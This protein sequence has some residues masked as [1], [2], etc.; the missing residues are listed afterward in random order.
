MSE[1]TR[2][3][4][5]GSD[6]VRALLRH[7][8]KSR[9]MTAEDKAR[10]RARVGRVAAGIAVGVGSLAWL[11]GVAIGAGLGLL[12]V[13]AAT[14]APALLSP[15]APSAVVTAR[16]PVSG[17]RA[18]PTESAASTAPM[19]APLAPPP[20]AA[21]V[22]TAPRPAARPVEAP[23]SSSR[24]GGTEPPSETDSLAQEAALLERARAALGTSPAEALSL[25]ETHASRFPAG[26]LGMERELVALD[27]LRHL[28]RTAEV[29]TRGEALLSRGQGGLY[30]ERIHK[31]LDGAH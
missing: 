6:P 30:A 23:P 12:T 9:G 14:I 7:A 24:G 5:E 19:D 16:A 31:L 17:P 11:Q 8:P 13:G 21:P 4:D 29:R 26:K 20:S 1:P 10:T 2:L 28:G 22:E 27:A 3:R 18:H 15:A 25:T